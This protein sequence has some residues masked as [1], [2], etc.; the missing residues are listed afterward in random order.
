MSWIIPRS[1]ITKRICCFPQNPFWVAYRKCDKICYLRHGRK[2]CGTQHHSRV[3]T[4]MYRYLKIPPALQAP[5]S[6][7]QWRNM[8]YWGIWACLHTNVQSSCR[9]SGRNFEESCDWDDQFCTSKTERKATQSCT[10][11]KNEKMVSNRQ[12]VWSHLLP[13]STNILYWILITY[14]KR[15]WALDGC[16]D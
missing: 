10:R 13:T 6:S 11:I 16:W 15:W 7:M 2:F 5:H 4:I 1:L 14:P 3:Q 12:L 9:K 8:R